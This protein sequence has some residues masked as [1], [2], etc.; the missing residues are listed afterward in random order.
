MRYDDCPWRRWH[1]AFLPPRIVGASNVPLLGVN[2]GKLG[3]LAEVT[4]E[5]IT[6]CIDD[7]VARNYVI[8]ERTVLKATGGNESKEYYALNEIVADRGSSPR[9][10]ELET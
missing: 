3:F 8:E 1:N 7:I 9:V 5:E 10:I 2:L 4:V 6:A